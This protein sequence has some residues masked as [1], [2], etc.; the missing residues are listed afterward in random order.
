MNYE[1]I[2]NSKKLLK[3]ASSYIGMIAEIQTK[4]TI[5]KEK[6]NS[7]P[8]CCEEVKLSIVKMNKD[9]ARYSGKIVKIHQELKSYGVFSNLE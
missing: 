4:A 5:Q 1:Q 3:K 2:K 6:L 7:H 8:F 9:L